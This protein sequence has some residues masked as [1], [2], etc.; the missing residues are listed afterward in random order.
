MEAHKIEIS[1]KT[2]IFTVFF[3]ILL[4]ILWIIKDI[5]FSLFIAFII[6]SALRPFVSILR[7]IKIPKYIASFIVFIGFLSLFVM[8]LVYAFPPLFMQFALF[9]RGTTL[10]LESL[11]AIDKYFDIGSLGNYIP[12][13]TTNVFGVVG[14]LFSNTIFVISTLFFSFYFLA[15]DKFVENVLIRFFAEKDVRAVSNMLNKVQKRMA[16]WFWG[17]ITLMTV[18]GVMTYIGLSLLGVPFAVPLAIIAGLLEAVPN[19]GPT[20]SVIPS[21]LIALPTSYFL[22]LSVLALYFIIQQLENNL[23]VPLIMKGVVGLNPIITLL[24]LLIGGKLGGVLGVILA[25]PT[26]L[27]LD[28][29]IT[30]VVNVKRKDRV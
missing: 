11:G 24:A 30:A 1:A 2:I 9:L 16:S 13:L 7:K 23:I 14:S 27:F 12:T 17:E 4:D 6:M 21:F 20:L 5:I 8:L 28:T 18:I 22:A 10:S 3:I 25:I 19:L 26:T 15:D 29:L